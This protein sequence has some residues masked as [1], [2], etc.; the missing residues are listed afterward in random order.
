MTGKQFFEKR[1]ASQDAVDTFRRRVIAV[2][3]RRKAFRYTVQGP[4]ILDPE[5][6]AQEPFSVM[7]SE[8][9]LSSAEI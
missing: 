7:T 6:A 5:L 2:S 4:P 9:D 8:D 1:E 3:S